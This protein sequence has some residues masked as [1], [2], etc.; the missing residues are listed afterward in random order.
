M[1]DLN[2]LIMIIL[3]I[4]STILK[5]SKVVDDTRT[6]RIEIYHKLTLYK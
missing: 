5:K 4:A 2:S 3:L 1:Q 6:L